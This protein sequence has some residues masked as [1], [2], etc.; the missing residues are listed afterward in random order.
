MYGSGPRTGSI[1]NDL[2]ILKRDREEG[3]NFKL[4]VDTRIDLQH[5]V[6]SISVTGMERCLQSLT[7]VMSEKDIEQ[8]YQIVEQARAASAASLANLPATTLSVQGTHGAQ[9]RLSKLQAPV[10]K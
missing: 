5:S 3:M 4:G 2:I 6:A 8:M 1:Y 7:E 10:T 9:V